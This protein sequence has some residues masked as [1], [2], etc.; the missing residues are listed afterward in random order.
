MTLIA[1]TW[2]SREF[3]SWSI[4]QPRAGSSSKS[5]PQAKDGRTI[6]VEVTAYYHAR[7][8]RR[9]ADRL[10]E[11][12]PT[13][14][15]ASEAE[16]DIQ[17][18]KE[19]GRRIRQPGEERLPRQHVAR[20]PHAAQRHPRPQPPDAGRHRAA[21]AGRATAEDGSREPPPA[22]DHQRHPRPVQDRGGPAGTRIRQFPSF[23][24]DRQCRLDH[25]RH[26][27]RARASSS[28]SIPTASPCG[29][30]AT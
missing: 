30:A 7:Q 17:Q 18:A 12:M 4:C 15:R 3:P 24:R 29:C 22:V 27:R 9:S 8:G 26:R 1:P 10:I 11:F 28:R 2:G 5:S 13:F 16:G 23:R 25:P 19:V 21:G 14:P 20:D 6:P